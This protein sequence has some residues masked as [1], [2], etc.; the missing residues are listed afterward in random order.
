MPYAWNPEA[1]P[2]WIKASVEAV[3]NGTD[4]NIRMEF[5]SPREAGNQRSRI[6]TYL[7][8]I[9]R[10]GELSIRQRKE[11]LLLHKRI[12]P[13]R[14]NECPPKIDSNVPMP[15][16]PGTATTGKSA[17][18]TPEEQDML[19]R[20]GLHVKVLPIGPVPYFTI[21]D[22]HPDGDYKYHIT[23]MEAIRAHLGDGFELK[24]LAQ[25]QG[26]DNGQQPQ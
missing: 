3:L 10:E 16:A 4:N 15:A 11:I 5:A 19:N 13:T 23:L 12:A 2:E 14:G 9:N 25:S 20:L 17:H 24:I 7:S 21:T 26:V 1:Y 6:Y 22:D 8:V 18:I